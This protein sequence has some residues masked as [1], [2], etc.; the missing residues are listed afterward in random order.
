MPIFY[1]NLQSKPAQKKVTPNWILMKQEMMG[2][3]V[4][5]AGRYAKAFSTR[6]RAITTPALHH[7]LSLYLNECFGK[8]FSC[9]QVVYSIVC[10]FILVGLA[11]LQY[12][13]SNKYISESN[14]NAQC[15]AGRKDWC[16]KSV[17]RQKT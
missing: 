12:L 11:G 16:L 4:A 5:S 9:R 10:C 3:A 1:D 8:Q 13:Q 2:V 6:S 14:G 17:V 15:R 7:C